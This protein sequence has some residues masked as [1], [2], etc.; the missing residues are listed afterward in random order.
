[1]RR[2]PKHGIKTVFGTDVVVNPEACAAQNDEFIAHLEWFTPA[3][4]LRHA[5]ALSG[6]LL[7]LSG[8]RSPYPGV[9]GKIEKG[10]L[11]D[12][13]LINGNPLED[14]SILTKP[15]EQLALIMKAGTVYKNM[16]DQQ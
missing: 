16:I 1:M 11:A 4:I 9:V 14:L 5:T 15:H 7:Q 3:E 10:A 12:L 6:K 2:T 13:L 8:D